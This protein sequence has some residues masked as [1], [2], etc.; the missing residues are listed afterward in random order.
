MGPGPAVS[1]HPAFAG[2]LLELEP[3][4]ALLRHDASPLAIAGDDGYSLFVQDAGEWLFCGSVADEWQTFEHLA[5]VVGVDVADRA[6]LAWC[7]VSHREQLQRVRAAR[8]LVDGW[9]NERDFVGP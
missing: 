4:V 1:V 7:E 2:F 5:A 6:W 3:R 9:P 8:N